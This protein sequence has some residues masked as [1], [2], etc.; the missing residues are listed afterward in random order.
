MP[1]H[2]SSSPC[3]IA[4]GGGQTDLAL[5]AAAKAV[6][7]YPNGF[8]NHGVLGVVLNYDGRPS[9]AIPEFKAAMRLS[10]VYPAWVPSYLSDS[11]VLSGDLDQALQSLETHMA[12]PPSSYSPYWEA[13]AR[14][15]LAVVYEA[16][17]REQEARDQVARAVEVFPRASISWFR[18]TRPYRDPTTLDEW[19][20]T[21][22]RLGMP[23]E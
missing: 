18:S 9:E 23:E 15:R 11:Y 19:A 1:L 16:M 5:E 3:S 22:R 8:M 7:L 12:R 17:G 13:F 10:P 20:E 4:I 21:W 14:S 2:M 6:E